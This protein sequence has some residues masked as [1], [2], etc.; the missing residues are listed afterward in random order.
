ML[1]RGL[2]P[3]SSP[4]GLPWINLAAVFSKLHNSQP[5]QQD[6]DQLVWHQLSAVR[7]LQED[8]IFDIPGGLDN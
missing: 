1:C 6:D 4:R 7:F 2:W 3:P 5:A 8:L